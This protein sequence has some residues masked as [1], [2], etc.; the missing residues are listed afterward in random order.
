M[1]KGG[2]GKLLI[3][4]LCLGPRGEKS[5]DSPF[6]PFSF[7][8]TPLCSFQPVSPPRWRISWCIVCS[9]NLTP[10]P[11]RHSRKKPR[12]VAI[13]LERFR[14]GQKCSCTSGLTMDYWQESFLQLLTAA[15]APLTWLHLQHDCWL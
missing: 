6:S 3:S 8:S 15:A 14:D 7:F 1:S 2:L 11:M 4:P 5:S 10:A 12:R 9:T 13:E